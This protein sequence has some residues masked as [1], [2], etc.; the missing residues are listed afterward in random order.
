MARIAPSG[1]PELLCGVECAAAR[2]TI[3]G[4]EL[5]VVVR[6]CVV[7]LVALDGFGFG[8]GLGVER[9]V[10]VVV[11]WSPTPG[12]LVVPGATGG[13]AAVTGGG[14][15]VL[16][17]V[18]G[19]GFVVVDAGGGGTASDGETLGCAWLPNANAS[20][21]PAFGWKSSTP[22]LLYVH[23]ASEGRAFQ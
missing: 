5:V 3:D 4:A 7:V 17:A 12:T 14:G 15:L 1:E 16:G 22:T 10:A 21:V 23:W 18:D 6:L 19:A 13:V 20:M 8:F 9:A 11:V 2:S